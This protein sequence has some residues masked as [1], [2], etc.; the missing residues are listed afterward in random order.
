AASY[1]PPRPADPARHDGLAPLPPATAEGA[2]RMDTTPSQPIQVIVTGPTTI[3]AAAPPP[4]AA[5]T[6]MEAEAAA[7]RNSSLRL[8]TTSRQYVQQLPHMQPAQGPPIVFSLEQ[9]MS[10]SATVTPTDC[11]DDAIVQP[12]TAHGAI[13]SS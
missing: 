13:T 5:T 3:V 4:S 10:G 9:L 6:V 8:L 12:E 1:G 11:R 2:S 7:H